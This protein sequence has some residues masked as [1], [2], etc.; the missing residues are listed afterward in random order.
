MFRFKFIQ[1]IVGI[2][3]ICRVLKTI[4]FQATTTS[5]KQFPKLGICFQWN[6]NISTNLPGHPSKIN[7]NGC[8]QARVAQLL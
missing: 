6:M 3:G 1:L 8:K 4:F 2:C 7:V 5:I